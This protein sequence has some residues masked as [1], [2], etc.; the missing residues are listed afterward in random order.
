M[1]LRSLQQD[2]LWAIIRVLILLA[3][4]PLVSIILGLILMVVFSVWWAALVLL[5]VGAY[6]AI[7]Y[8][9]KRSVSA[10]TRL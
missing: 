1:L 10:I 4:I 9:W 6:V 8:L 7:F 5:G 2:P 3:A